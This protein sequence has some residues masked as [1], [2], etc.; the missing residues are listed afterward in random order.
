MLSNVIQTIRQN[1]EEPSTE[2]K[3][4]KTRITGS[5]ADF[6]HEIRVWNVHLTRGCAACAALAVMP[7]NSIAELYYSRSANHDLGL[8]E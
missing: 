7:L 4:I 6:P 3:A 1:G 8:R 2:K 5:L